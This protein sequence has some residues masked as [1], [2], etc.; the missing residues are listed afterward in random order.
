LA[1]GSAAWLWYVLMRGGYGLKTMLAAA[2]GGHGQ[3][4][5]GDWQYQQVARTYFLRAYALPLRL[6]VVTLLLSIGCGIGFLGTLMTW[7]PHSHFFDMEMACV[8]GLGIIRLYRPR[9]NRGTVRESLA[10]DL[11]GQ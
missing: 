1:A 5:D 2:R 8:I 9:M 4:I 3:E 7:S 11:G 6:S 10:A